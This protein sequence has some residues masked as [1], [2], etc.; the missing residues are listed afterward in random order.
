MLRQALRTT[1]ALIL[2][3]CLL[4]DKR[5]SES[6]ERRADRHQY[7]GHICRR[8]E[9]NTGGTFIYLGPIYLFIYFRNTQAQHMQ[10]TVELQVDKNIVPLVQNGIASGL[11]LYSLYHLY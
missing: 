4:S 3:N 7:A 2:L 8:Q 10:P 6:T 1:S 5:V 11:Q 9:H